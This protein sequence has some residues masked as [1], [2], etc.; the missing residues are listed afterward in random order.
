MDSRS[1]ANSVTYALV[2]VDRTGSR[3]LLTKTNAGLSLPTVKVAAGQRVAPQVAEQVWKHWALQACCLFVAGQGQSTI[4]SDGTRYAV[5]ERIADNEEAPPGTRW[6]ARDAIPEL[7]GV[8]AG[9]KSVERAFRELDSYVRSRT[10]AAFGKPGWLRELFTWVGGLMAL[11]CERLTGDFWQF[12]ASPDF[13]LLRLE[14]T[15][16][17]VWFKATGEPNRHELSVTLSLA[18]LFPDALPQIL[19]VHPKWNGWLMREF[20]GIPLSKSSRLDA[21]FT[22]ARELGVLQVRSIGKA[23]ALKRAKCKD[24]KLPAL[25]RDIDSF[26]SQMSAL[27]AAQAKQEP[28]PLSQNELDILALRLKAACSLLQH[29]GL[30]DTLGTLDCNP[31]NI[32]VH[33]ERCVFLDWADA[34]VSNPL[35]TYEHFKEHFR[36]HC[37]N[38]PEAI[39]HFAA[40]YFGPWE[41]VVSRDCLDQARL[42]SPL[43]AVFQFAAASRRALRPAALRNESIAGYFRSLVRRMHREARQVDKGE[44]R[45]VA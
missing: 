16:D 8:T 5:V 15:G 43:V 34:C 35:I 44:Q 2:I 24:F 22:A 39:K 14:T 45:C 40:A 42:N 4:R 37:L 19:G 31:G 26:M 25:T 1:K 3:L 28:R 9:T 21:W 11:S 33:R 29:A 18:Q 10:T 27:M 20:R 30:P 13:T 41:A 38:E 32:L 6:V 12:N 17:A 23:A 36:R 7:L